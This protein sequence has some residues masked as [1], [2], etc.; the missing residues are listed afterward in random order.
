M[1]IRSELDLPIQLQA[2]RSYG[3]DASHDGILA[4]AAVRDVVNDLIAT[5]APPR[6]VLDDPLGVVERVF[7]LSPPAPENPTISP[8]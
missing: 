7:T 5:A 1:T 2:T 8:P 4:D 3:F 6:G